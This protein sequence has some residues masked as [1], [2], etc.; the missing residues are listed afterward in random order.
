MNNQAAESLI[1]IAGALLLATTV[2]WGGSQNYVGEIVLWLAITLI[3]LP[4]L[5]GW[6]NVALISPLCVF[7]LLTRIIGIPPLE[8]R[9]E[10]RWGRGSQVLG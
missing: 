5:S 9:V 7:L 3:A 10:E 1:A 6:Q 2:A 4:A 8:Y